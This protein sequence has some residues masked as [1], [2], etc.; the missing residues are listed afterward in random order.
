MTCIPA[1][2]TYVELPG[3]PKLNL[4]RLNSA[5]AT[6]VFRVKWDQ[7]G[8]FA[9]AMIGGWSIIAGVYVR[10]QA[11]PFPDYTGLIASSASIEP[12]MS[13]SPSGGDIISLS[14][15]T[16]VYENAKVTINYRVP[17][18][19]PEESEDDDL[20]QPEEGTIL[21]Y[22]RQTGGQ[23]LSTP[24]RSWKWADGPKASTDVNPGITIPTI[25]HTLS[26]SNVPYSKVPWDDIKDKMGLINSA[27]YL[28]SAP[29]RLLFTGSEASRMWDLEALNAS[30]PL[31]AWQL[32]YTFEESCKPPG[33]GWN[34]FWREKRET[35]GN[36][37]W[38]R[39]QTDDGNA[40]EAYEA[41][42]FKSLTKFSVVG[43]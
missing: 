3:S 11:T 43:P 8:N 35:V 40:D 1:G 12:D 36:S 7:R 13:D 15:G 28:D 27:K 19:A 33:A 32:Q 31:A 41:V 16:A 9:A 39:L 30:E 25:V 10:R 38:V 37:H 18:P 22:S 26:W 6:R 4:D 20:D 34:H 14:V 17:E 23:I 42:S 2:Y 5:T 24:G 29:E 21:E